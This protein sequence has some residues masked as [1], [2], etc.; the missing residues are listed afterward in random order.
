MWMQHRK[1]APV[2]LELTGLSQDLQKF[3]EEA[4][5]Q[6]LIEPAADHP[7]TVR[8]IVKL[9]NGVRLDRRF[10]RHSSTKVSVK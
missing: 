3:K 5:N 8:V 6:L 4:K 7:D 1:C 2:V 10:L 9:P